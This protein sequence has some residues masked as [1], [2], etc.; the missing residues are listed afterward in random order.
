MGIQFVG[1]IVIE[2]P[3]DYIFVCLFVGSVCLLFSQYH[4]AFVTVCVCVC[5]C[6]YIYIYIYI[7]IYTYIYILVNLE[8]R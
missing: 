2:L 1:M 7:H 3:L 4:A 5:V 6:V 8:I